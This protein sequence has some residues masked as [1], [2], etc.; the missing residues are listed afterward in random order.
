MFPEIA[1]GFPPGPSPGRFEVVYIPPMASERGP[2]IAAEETARRMTMYISFLETL[3]PLL[4]YGLNLENN[5]PVD[6]TAFRQGIV[7]D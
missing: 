5:P 7:A 3:P 2:A 6:Q 1:A 4:C